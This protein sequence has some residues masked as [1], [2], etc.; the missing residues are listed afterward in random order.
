MSSEQRTLEIGEEIMDR[1]VALVRADDLDGMMTFAL[2]LAASLVSAEDQIADLRARLDALQPQDDEISPETEPETGG[3]PADCAWQ[4]PE[5]ETPESAPETEPEGEDLSA[6]FV[7]RTGDD[8]LRRCLE[9]SASRPRQ[10]SYTDRGA[11]RLVPA[12]RRHAKRP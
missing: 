11:D 10:A 7:M 12:W 6:D 9:R 8:V 3:S 5:P 1:A 2:K 4:V